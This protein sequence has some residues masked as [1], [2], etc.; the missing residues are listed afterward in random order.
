MRITAS[1]QMS[2]AFSTSWQPAYDKFIGSVFW[3]CLLFGCLANTLEMLFF[4]RE[5]L[6]RST[7]RGRREN[8]RLYFSLLYLQ[9][10]IKR[11]NQS[12]PKFTFSEIS[13]ITFSSKSVIFQVAAIVNQ[14]YSQVAGIVNRFY[15]QVAAIVDRFY[16]QLAAI[17]NRFYFQVAAI[18]CRFYF[19]AAAIVNRFYFQVAAIVNRFYLQ[20]AAIVNRFYFQVAAIDV[21]ICYTAFPVAL[22]YLRD[23]HPGMFG[24]RVFCV[25]WGFL[26]EII[27]YISVY[28]MAVMAFSR[29]KTL[30]FPLKNLSIKAM[31]VCFFCYL[32]LCC[33]SKIVPQLILYDV[34]LTYPYASFHFNRDSLYCFLYPMGRYWLVNS[35]QS[36]VQLGLPAP[37]IVCSC[38]T[39]LCVLERLRRRCKKLSYNQGNSG[40]RPTT[41]IIILRYYCDNC[42]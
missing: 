15:L 16:F 35:V 34:S 42:R 8:N 28:L 18:V 5:T 11:F 26:W 7:R 4:Y 41:T 12:L 25:I 19:Q 40:R 2:T 30:T 33:I 21:V 36:T 1:P 22:C 17:V 3:L 10:A 14:F 20:V 38:V 9:V 37:V 39:C 29:A 6:N 23:R 31:A 32:I 13:F 27:P 24:D